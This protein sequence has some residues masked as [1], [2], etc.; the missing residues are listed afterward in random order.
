MKKIQ[1][2]FFLLIFCS[3]I[4][5][6]YSQQEASWKE[7]EDFHTVMSTT[8]HPADEGNFKPL[9]ERAGELV[10]K[11]TAW[12]NSVVPEGYIS[13]LTKSILKRLVQQCRVVKDAVAKKR[14][15]ADLKIKITKAHE[16]FHEIKEKC[17]KPENKL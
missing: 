16:I 7:M 4:P 15:D 8:F 9:K 5:T 3:L 14:P 1:I 12:Q 17:L 6:V 2:L 13:S 10:I 11:A